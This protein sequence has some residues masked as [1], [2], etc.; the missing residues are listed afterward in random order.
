MAVDLD[1]GDRR[2]RLGERQREGAE[3]GADLYVAGT[4]VFAGND[5]TTYAGRIAAIR[6]AATTVTA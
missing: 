1:R 4:S 6:N 2:T 5:P 3:A